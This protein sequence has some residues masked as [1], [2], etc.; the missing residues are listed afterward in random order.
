MDAREREDR[1]RR[2]QTLPEP[3]RLEDLTAAQAVEPG[4]DSTWDV[5]YE[6]YWAA[7]E[8]GWAR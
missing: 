7:H 5:D 3:V 2:W 8:A 1:A 6:R 4:R